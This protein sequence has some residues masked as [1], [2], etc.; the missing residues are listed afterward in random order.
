[1]RV[2]DRVTYAGIVVA[3]LVVDWGLGM[4][5]ASGVAPLWTFLVANSP[6]GAVYVWMESSWSGTHY[7]MLGQ[8]AGDIGSL[9]IWAAVALAQGSLYC[10][11]W[12]VLTGKRPRA[13]EDLS[14]QAAAG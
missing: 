13:H 12:H 8:R 11:L 4:L 3:T 9:I 14:H 5:C 6:F 7:V 2:K 10:V 1:M